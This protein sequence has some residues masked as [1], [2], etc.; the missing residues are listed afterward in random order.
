MLDVLKTEVV[1]YVHFNGI[2]YV[3]LHRLIATINR[4]LQSVGLLYSQEN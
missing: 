1:P 4:Y 3:D 2:R